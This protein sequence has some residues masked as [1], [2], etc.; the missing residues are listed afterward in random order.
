MLARALGEYG[1]LAAAAEGVARLSMSANAW[2][3][4]WGF[5]AQV[6][7]GIVVGSWVIGK[8]VFR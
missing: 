4:E 7:G 3:D 6:V 8:L 1:S 5:A 2:I